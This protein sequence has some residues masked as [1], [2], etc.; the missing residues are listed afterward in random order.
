M[1][2]TAI[3]LQGI[4]KA[5]HVAEYQGSAP[6][7][8]YGSLRDSLA[9]GFLRM[10]GRG[11]PPQATHLFWALKDVSCEIRHGEILG[12]IGRNGAGK[13]TLLKVISRITEPTEGIGEVHGRIGSLLEV[14]TGFHP[15]LTGRENILLSG[16]ILGMK[17]A[18]VMRKFDEIVAFAGIEPFLETPVKRYSS[19][20]FVRLAFGVAV[21]LEPEILV[22][23]EVLAVGDAEFQRKCLD[24]L[25]SIRGEGRTI[26]L[27]SHNM[28]AIRSICTR[29]IVLHHGQ[30]VAEGDVNTVADQYLSG[31]LGADSID[32]AIETK[33]C[34]VEDIS[35]RSLDGPVIKTSDT[36]EIMVE[37][38]AKTDIQDPGLLMGILSPDHQ[39][40][41]GLDSKD[42]RTFPPLRQ[43]ERMR[44]GFRIECFPCLP[45]PWY[46]EIQVGELAEWEFEPTGPPFRFDVVESPVYG[47]RQIGP[48]HGQ[49]ALSARAIGGND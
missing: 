47:P 34:I 31:A 18:E 46:L 14:G 17:R 23:D 4:G 36:V 24:K 41:T 27:V 49:I 39:R 35:I 48:P 44:M 38:R 1:S 32:R 37:V 2:A 25:R 45:G 3:R 26:L 40:V 33:R 12:V 8:H 5:Y 42:F 22:V 21:H 28:A 30:I 10:V 9:R 19:G 6:R 29:G 7:L 11:A 20:M 43:G 15:E 13:S 16:T